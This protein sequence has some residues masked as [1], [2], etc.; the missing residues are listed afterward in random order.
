MVDVGNDADGAE[1]VDNAKDG[2]EKAAV[3]EMDGNG[4]QQDG[5]PKNSINLDRTGRCI[6]M[7][8]LVK[9][10][11]DEDG[12]E[13]HEGGVILEAAHSGADV[14]GSRHESLHHEG[15]PHRVVDPGEIRNA[16][17]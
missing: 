3:V 6:R 11:I 10:H 15:A 8:V 4:F 14:V 12:D 2:P 1:D 5:N 7:S 13:V 9:L 17:V 16:M